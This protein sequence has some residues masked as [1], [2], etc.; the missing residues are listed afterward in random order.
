MKEK[1]EDIEKLTRDLMK[2]SILSPESADFDDQLMQKISEAP[3]PIA[4]KTN[5][6]DA[7]KAWRLWM[8]T[9]VFLIG[10]LFIVSEY[11]AGYFTE[12]SRMLTVTLNYV[13]Y[14]G[15]ALFIPFVLFQLDSL[16]QVKTWQ[17]RKLT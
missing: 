15:M 12:L 17:R 14:G 7:K 9:I 8:I 3:A 2:R 5:G 1:R 6:S 16:L 13:F 10:S 4:L 11:L